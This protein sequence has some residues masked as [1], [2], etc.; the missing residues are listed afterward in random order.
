MMIIRFI[1]IF[2]LFSP[3]HLVSQDTTEQQSPDR[4]FWG[5]DNKLG[6]KTSLGEILG[7]DSESFYL[8]KFIGSGENMQ[9]YLEQ[10]GL[11]NFAIIN[12]TSLPLVQNKGED[13]NVEASWMVKDF[14]WIF[15]T[16]YNKK[17]DTL[18]SYTQQFNLDGSQ[19]GK[20]NLIDKLYV[21][22]KKYIG[23]YDFQLSVDSSNVLVAYTPPVNKYEFEERRLKMLDLDNQVL[24]SETIELSHPSEYFQVLKRIVPDS[25]HVY[26]LG[27]AYSNRVNASNKNHVKN[28]GKYMLFNYNLGD[29]S[30]N[31]A[32]LALNGKYIT[33]ATMAY[34]KDKNLYVIGLY[35]R[36]RSFTVSGAFYL[37]LDM[38]TGTVVEKGFSDFDKDL[39]R[40]FISDKKVRNNKELDSFEI[41]ELFIDSIGQITLIAEQYYITTTTYTDPRTG[42]VIYTYYYHFNDV[43]IIKFGKDG[44][45]RWGNRLAKQQQSLDDRG[46]YSSYAA[47][48]YEN[49]L[50][51]IYN[52]NPKNLQ[53]N[54]KGGGMT[55]IWEMDDPQKSVAVFVKYEGEEVGEREILFAA[56]EA[57]Y[58]FNPNIIYRVDEKTLILFAQGWKNYRFVRVWAK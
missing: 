47:V 18:Y 22:S 33:S 46:Y 4:V 56:K 5:P 15:T 39:L 1:L 9:S 23:D 37:K 51:I 50:F 29:H 21:Q 40:E 19:R 28:T 34:D 6:S 16:Y 52:D 38:K 11:N 30:L 41:R 44:R 17:L 58:I 7:D 14:I 13:I 25:S 36:T 12:S 31:E 45:I 48:A 49:N 27:V 10:Y 43:L 3:L 35:S 54:P 2:L 8:L 24:W 42:H 57:E 32:Q 55:T 20:R 53:Y 26:I